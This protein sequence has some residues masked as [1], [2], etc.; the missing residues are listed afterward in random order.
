MSRQPPSRRHAAQGNERKPEEVEPRL[1][2]TDAAPPNDRRPEE[3][4]LRLATTDAALRRLAAS[5]ALAPVRIAGPRR[6]QLLSVYFDTPALALRAAGTAAR[7]RRAG[8][9]PTWIQTLKTQARDSPFRDEYEGAV[10][11]ARPDLALA[12]R[13]GWKGAP[14]L[15][16]RDAEL[17]PIFSTHVARTTRT[18][19]FADG[20]VA[21]LAVDR[22]TLRA[23]ARARQPILEIEIE[24]KH[25]SARRLYELAYRIVAELPSTRVLAASKAE[26]GYELAT[27]KP[28]PPRRAAAIG[29]SRK[30]DAGTIALR[31]AVESLVH[32]QANVERARSGDDPEGVHQMRVG[33]RRLR[34]SATL[35]AKAG[36]PGFSDTLRAELKWLWRALGEARDWDVL[37]TQTWP[38]VKREARARAPAPDGFDAAVARERKASQRSL[39]RALDSRRFQYVLLAVGSVVAAQREAL[40]AAASTEPAKRFTQRIVARRA[41]R[42][43]RHSADVENLADRRR[44]RLRIEAKKLRY[45][46]EFFAGAFGRRAARRYLR[47]LASAQTVLGELNDLAV[48]LARVRKV[49]AKL[50]PASRRRALDA[51]ERYASRREPLL[52]NELA[53]KWSEFAKAA[54][55]WS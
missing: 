49:A 45:T 36:L 7:L 32:V 18:L 5:A 34:A 2:T 52:R 19:T 8:D 30:S 43:L 55:F 13:Q 35:A 41:R 20:T 42:I 17:R 25:G 31:A 12:R 50:P 53:E 39:R 37:A 28:A 26:R 11:G 46:A 24:L 3:V 54:P 4:E 10:A 14:V 33:V 48:M 51:W 27:R 22:G 15:I 21:E 44:H 29:V 38:A 23:G 1:G 16:G 47:R 9:D 6:Q 40:A